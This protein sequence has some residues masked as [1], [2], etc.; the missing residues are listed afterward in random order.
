[1][2]PTEAIWKAQL[3]LLIFFLKCLILEWYRKEEA[4]IVVADFPIMESWFSHWNNAVQL[5]LPKKYHLPQTLNI[6]PYVTFF[7]EA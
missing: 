1:M 7:S 5:F 4:L 3:Y 6:E 2:L